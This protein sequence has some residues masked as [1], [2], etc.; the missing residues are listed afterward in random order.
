MLRLV[1]E[2]NLSDRPVEYY[3]DEKGLKQGT[4]KEWYCYYDEKALMVLKEECQ[5]KDNLI[6]GISR[7][8]TRERTLYSETNYIHGKKEGEQKYYNDNGKVTEIQEYKDNQKNGKMKVWNEDGEL[9]LETNY[10]NNK[11]N[12][13]LKSWFSNGN[14]SHEH[15]YKDD[16]INGKCKDYFPDGKLREEAEYKDGKLVSMIALNDEKGRDCFL[17]DGTIILWKACKVEKFEDGW[18][19]DKKLVFVKL[20][21][22]P[23]AK[24]V[25]PKNTHELYKGRVS[26]AKVME[27][28]DEQGNKY[29]SAISFVWS[30]NPT[31]YTVGEN[32]VPTGFN[33]DPNEECGAGINAHVYQDQCEIWKERL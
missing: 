6:E 12:G 2:T 27:I 9:R 26:L 15:N 30:N 16:I 31:T 23:E 1:Q 22:A 19:K 7:V 10:K 4:Y 24:R 29:D 14:L 13:E 5:Y 25:T 32:V 11:R 20:L 18:R 21:V 8:W 17:H 28:F 3:V 33:D